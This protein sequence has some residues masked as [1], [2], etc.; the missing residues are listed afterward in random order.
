[1]EQETSLFVPLLGGAEASECVSLRESMFKSSWA[2][3]EAR[4]QGILRE[5]N[6]ATL[7]EVTTFVQDETS[8]K[9]VGC[10]EGAVE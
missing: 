9:Y 6:S 1:M 4:V 3:V 7:D 8:P 5:A 10:H 2:T